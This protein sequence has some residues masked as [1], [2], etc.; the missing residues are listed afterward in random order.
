MRIKPVGLRKFGD[1]WYINIQKDG[2]RREI[3]AGTDLAEAIKLRNRLRGAT[4]ANPQPLKLSVTI[5]QAIDEHKVQ[6]LNSLK[7]AKDLIHCLHSA[8]ETFGG[9]F[10][11]S[12]TWE[13]LETF[14]NKRL[15]EVAPSYVRKE[16]HMLHAV[17]ARQIRKGVID[18]NP[19][20]FVEKP[21]FNDTRELILSHDEFVRL[22]S[23]S[24]TTKN[25]GSDQVNIMPTHTVLAL[26]I[27]DYTAMRISE[28]LSLS[29][30]NVMFDKNV[31][32]V[33][34]SKNGEG[35]FVPL[36]PELVKILQYLRTACPWVVNHNEKR[37][38][39]IRKGFD[40]ARAKAGLENT[41]I[42]DLRH[43][44]ITRWVQQGMNLDLIRMV[45]GHK[46]YS[47]FSRYSNLKTSDIQLLVG[48]KIEPLPVISFELYS[49][50]VLRVNRLIG[51][52]KA[53]KTWENVGT[54]KQ[55]I[56]AAAVSS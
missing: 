56:T 44:A 23:V 35:R 25:H 41:R 33:P 50:L 43:R 42:H 18:K 6:H 29:W 11:Q 34:T 16:L 53:D 22:L 2:V 51:P 9:R 48:G 28:V 19:I 37:I 12:I 13:E 30:S 10:I 36:H 8:K 21:K 5:A 55:A 32:F 17:F 20:D 14:K 31:I 4:L 7:S 15:G 26:V 38:T 1:I 40:Q 27:A 47:S 52:V 45:S 54:D 39:T 24:W 3:P 46:T 49:S